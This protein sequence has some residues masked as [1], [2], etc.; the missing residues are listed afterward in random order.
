MRLNPHP[1]NVL[2]SSRALVVFDCEGDQI[3]REQRVDVREV[4]DPRG[5]GDSRAFAR[6]Y[7]LDPHIFYIED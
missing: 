6:T 4:G 1:P 5:N 2:V 3:P 7:L